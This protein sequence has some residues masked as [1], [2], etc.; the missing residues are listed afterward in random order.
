MRALVLSGGGFR[1]A[2]QVPVLQFLLENYDYD[3]IYGVSV[4][5]LNGVMCAQGDLEMLWDLWNGLDGISS[6]LRLR[7]WWPFYGLY[8][9]K[10]LRKK[11]EERISLDKIKIPFSAGV[12]SLT[13]GEYYN[14]HTEDMRIDDELWDA[15]EASSCIAGMMVPPRIFINGGSHLGADGGFRNIIPVPEHGT[16]EEVHV[17]T[18][19]PLQRISPKERSI[20]HILNV[21]SRGIEIMEDEIF[22]RDYL[23]IRDNAPKGGTV[24]IYAPQ[25]DPGPSFEAP[26]EA[27]LQRFKLGEEAIKHPIVLTRSSD[28]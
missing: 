23:Q 26:R 8:S 18:C 3:A 20:W 12:V 11:L 9:M 13:N 17:V 14:L 4:G 21:A 27:I 5:A 15:V 22:D 24:T 25:H 28:L 10:P 6:F 7:W 1:G 19:T 16:F 2:V